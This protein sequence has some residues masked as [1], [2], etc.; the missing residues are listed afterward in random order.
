MTWL[1]YFGL[2]ITCVIVSLMT[3]IA[4]DAY[5]VRKAD[6]EV[7]EYEQLPVTYISPDGFEW[8]DLTGVA[9]APPDFDPETW[10]VVY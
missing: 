10:T 1:Q 8:V 6:E 4:Y 9:P 3:C 2:I 5:Y 7:G